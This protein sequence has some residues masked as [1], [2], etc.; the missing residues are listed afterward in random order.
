MRKI[1]KKYAKEI[2][3]ICNICSLC[4]NHGSDDGTNM[5]NMHELLY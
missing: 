3:K 5:Q 2:F 4:Q 1:C